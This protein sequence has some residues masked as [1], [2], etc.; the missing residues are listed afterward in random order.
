MLSHILNM[1]LLIQIDG[2]EQ[3]LKQAENCWT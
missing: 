3:S 1:L 2:I